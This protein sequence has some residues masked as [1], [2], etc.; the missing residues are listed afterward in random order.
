[1]TNTGAWQQ[2]EDDDDDDDIETLVRG[3]ASS[4]TKRLHAG[5]RLAV[6]K[7]G[8]DVSGHQFANVCG[9]VVLE[10]LSI[11]VEICECR[12]EL[13]VVAVEVTARVVTVVVVV[14]MMVV[15]VVVRMR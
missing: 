2:D 6:N 14:V 13:M 4:V 7:E 12:G 10:G 8:G 9:R 11:V 1:M 5:T 15:M 3:V